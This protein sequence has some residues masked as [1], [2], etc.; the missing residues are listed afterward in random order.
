MGKLKGSM[1]VI[2]PTEPKSRIGR[3]GIAG[4]SLLFIAVDDNGDKDKDDSGSHKGIKNSFRQWHYRV[5]QD[6][7]LGKPDCCGTLSKEV[8]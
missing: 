7:V 1:S 8:R 2:T 3:F 5:G 6:T 4:V